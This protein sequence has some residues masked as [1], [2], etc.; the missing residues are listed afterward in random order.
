MATK[1]FIY[2]LTNET[3]SGHDWVKIG[4]ATDVE[5]RRKELSTTALPFPYEIYA[6]YEIP[7]TS[8]VADKVLHKL[9]T[10]LN[11]GLRLA[12][13]REFFEMKPEAAYDLLHAL[14]VIHDC[15][16][17]LVRYKDGKPIVTTSSCP[18]T[19]APASVVT[20]PIGAAPSALPQ[21]KDYHDSFHID[22]PGGHA[23][24]T[25]DS[26]AFVVK[27]GSV[28]RLRSDPLNPQRKHQLEDLADGTL[29]QTGADYASL[30]VDK[31]FKSPSSAASYIN[32][33]SNDGWKTWKDKNGRAME[34]V[35]QRS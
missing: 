22:I 13:N 32:A 26:G 4:Y 11:P 17:K 25:V 31:A 21:L 34:T 33:R 2:V 20:K 10:Q 35:V 1:A 18:T 3:F 9:I 7:P 23:E 16:D 14:A 24:M 8:H 6:T 30:T 29:K 27:V 19:S 5:R 15:E 28:V 12:K